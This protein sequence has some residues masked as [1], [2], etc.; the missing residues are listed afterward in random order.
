MEFALAFEAFKAGTEMTRGEMLKHYYDLLKRVGQL[1]KTNAHLNRVNQKIVREKRGDNPQPAAQHKPST[2]CR[3]ETPAVAKCVHGILH[4][5]WCNSYGGWARNCGID[6]APPTAQPKPSPD[7]SA[8]VA[9]LRKAAISRLFEA[10]MADNPDKC[11]EHCTEYVD[12]AAKF[13][14]AV[15]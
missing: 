12:A 8:I 10:M 13:L 7:R 11:L 6:F 5:L 4:G 3:S 14:G 9:D 15:V 1:Q 2:V